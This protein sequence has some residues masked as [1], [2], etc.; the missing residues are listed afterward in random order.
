[1]LRL[2][3]SSNLQL[4]FRNQAKLQAYQREYARKKRAPG[5]R[6][7]SKVVRY[8]LEEE[9][10]EKRTL[11]EMEGL[12]QIPNTASQ[13]VFFPLSIWYSVFTQTS[14]VYECA[15]ILRSRAVDPQRTAA[16]VAREE[17]AR[18]HFEKL[19]H[20]LPKQSPL[21]WK[22]D[23]KKYVD[24]FI[25]EHLDEAEIVTTLPCKDE[26]EEEWDRIYLH[27][28][29]RLVAGAGQE[30]EL[31]QQPKHAAICAELEGALVWQGRGYV[32]RI[33]HAISLSNHLSSVN[34]RK[35]RQ[36]YGW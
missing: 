2:P 36:L 24:K 13:C 9:Y 10:V 16:M 31:V 3:V 33:L 23:F 32:G 27:G 21:S 7:V 1:M 11:M 15:L 6:K 12:S 20:I 28:L 5:R 17:K 14:R 34:L 19:K 25:K 29:R 4:N 35:F 22:K 8:L 30:W 26:E 18:Q